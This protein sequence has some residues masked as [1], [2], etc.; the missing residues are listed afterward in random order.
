LKKRERGGKPAHQRGGQAQLEHNHRS[1]AA[2][3]V[4]RRRWGEVTEREESQ[5]T[6]R[7][8]SG[9]WLGLELEAFF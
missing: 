8:G 2:G 9:L 5:R 3:E 7:K 4:D 6:D 1:T